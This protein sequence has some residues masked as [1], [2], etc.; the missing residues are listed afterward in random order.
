MEQQIE[1]KEK[2][3]HEAILDLIVNKDE[4]TWQSII[5]DLVNSEKMDPWNIDITLLTKRYIEVI[6]KLK[7]MD[8]RVSGKVL[9]AAALLLRIKSVRL[10]T[11][12]L[13]ELDRLFVDEDSEEELL[14]EEDFVE[15]TSREEIP[16]L[17]PRTPQPR[18]RKLSVYDLISALEKALEVKERK[19]KR[20]IPEEEIEIPKK[21]IDIGEAIKKI[22]EKIKEF[23]S[24]KP[25]ARLT[26]SKLVPSDKKEDKVYTF[27]P[28]LHLSHERKID[29]NQYEHFGE[30]EIL[31]KT[32][33]EID[34]ELGME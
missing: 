13:D 24:M 11:K 5:Y 32:K 34:K 10:V 22:Y 33:E 9:L 29:L 28:L 27:I 16:S 25:K 1:F 21:K 6:K 26:F 20:I 31:L 30:I 7:K 8:F 19:L 3:P 23:F 4:I 18:K 12:D 14:F 2:E 15:E 17:I